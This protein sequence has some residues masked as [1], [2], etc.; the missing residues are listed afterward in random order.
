MKLEIS[1]DELYL[2]SLVF[3][4]IAGICYDVSNLFTFLILTT[5]LMVA[6]DVSTDQEEESLSALDKI[7]LQTM[8]ANIFAQR[9]V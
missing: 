2:L 1:W 7:L 5:F 3:L 8:I 6:I 4:P 9:I